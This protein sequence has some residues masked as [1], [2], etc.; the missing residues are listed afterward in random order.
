MRLIA[1]HSG[2]AANS[3]IAWAVFIAAWFATPA[4]IAHAATMDWKG[5][6]WQLTSGGM[7]GNCQGDAKNVTLDSNGYLHLKISHD[8]GTWSAAELFTTDRLGFGTYQWQVDAPI[9]TFDPNVVLGL[10]PYGPQAG[11]GS[12]RHLRPRVRTG[13]GSWLR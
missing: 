3:P 4:T 8:A 9:D 7:A 6:T 12:S 2:R 5:H 13:T 1:L 11:I 10:Y